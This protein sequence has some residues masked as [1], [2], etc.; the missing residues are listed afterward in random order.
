MN[1]FCYAGGMEVS[2]ES[3]SSSNPTTTMHPQY[4]QI[5]VIIYGCV[6]LVGILDH[7]IG[8]PPTSPIELEPNIRLAIFCGALVF[9]CLLELLQLQRTTPHLYHSVLHIILVTMLS[10]VALFV[11]NMNYSQ[12]LFLT[13]ILFA[14]LTLPRWASLL[15]IGSAFFFLFL[16]RAFGESRN[17]ISL[18]DVQGL[19]IFVVMMLFIWLMARLIKQEWLNRLSLHALHDEL[20]E[21]SA[22]LAHMAVIEE[23][24]RMAR[25]IHD[26]VG[27]H[28]AAV[29]IQLEMATKL[30]AREPDASLSAIHQAQSS[31]HDAL[32]DVRQ[33]VSALRQA[34]DTFA[35]APAIELLIGRMTNNQ[36]DVNC[37]F[38]GDERLYPQPVRLVMFRAI[39]EGLTNIYKHASAAHVNLWLQFLPGQAR[40]RLID[41]GAGFDPLQTTDGNGLL[42][43]RE[44]VEALGGTLMIDSRLEEGT[45]LDITL[46]HTPV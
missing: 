17:F 29:S 1:G 8:R 25:D 43:L 44:R 9:M 22:Q 24:N 36:F 21:T 13:P 19:L 30:H 6:L 2:A 28:L 10:S 35:L 45:I 27:H 12:L 33:S 40:L 46:P 15:T 16:R 7:V 5:A 31:A 11:S 4:R 14:E 34:D 41:D 38:D 42:G 20:K 26:S 37:H 32:Q 39:Q 23:R 18:L 3:L